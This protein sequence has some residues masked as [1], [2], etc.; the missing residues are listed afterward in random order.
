MQN[1]WSFGQ[2]KFLE[3]NRLCKT[4]SIYD[5][6]CCTHLRLERV[7]ELSLCGRGVKDTGY[8][9]SVSSGGQFAGRKD[10]GSHWQHPWVNTDACVR[11]P[12]KTWRRQGKT[13]RRQK[14]QNRRLFGAAKVS[15]NKQI[16]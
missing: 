6:T 1:R 5:S 10:E 15:G 14:M 13:W 9:G 11:I 8:S 4:L 2:Q 7:Q 12:G 3:T 16:M